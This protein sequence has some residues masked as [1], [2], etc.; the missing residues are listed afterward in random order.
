M[1][2]LTVK[3]TEQPQ[4]MTIWKPCETESDS[5]IGA[6]K[7]K[8]RLQGKEIPSDK[9]TTMVLKGM[10]NQI[11]HMKDGAD[12]TDPKQKVANQIYYLV[13]VI[14]KNYFNASVDSNKSAFTEVVGV[15]LQKFNG[16][17]L[18]EVGEAF[19]M[20]ASG[21]LGEVNFAA[22]GGVFTVP[23]FTDILT[24]FS[25]K[26]N[27]VAM[28]IYRANSDL[29]EKAKAD[30]LVKQKQDEY[31]AM[32]VHRH[33]AEQNGNHDYKSYKDVPHFYGKTLLEQGLISFTAE[34]KR[35]IWEAAKVAAL[36]ELKAEV[37]VKQNEFI[38]GKANKSDITRLETIL[39]DIA[40]NPKS[41]D[42]RTRATLI[43][44][45]MMYFESVKKKA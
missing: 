15:I 4:T 43:S 21:E 8:F 22:Y 36:E 24:K 29:E 6:A 32:L 9:F 39:A 2:Q 25:K 26:R 5:L 20:A 28:A 1:E 33:E 30:E 17:S 42:L 19:R 44:Y 12:L 3:K 10:Q 23:N 31:L 13:T 27:E 16:L 41:D 40:T 7:A 45:R 35:T 14:G 11:K 34:E 18:D 37:K 38:D